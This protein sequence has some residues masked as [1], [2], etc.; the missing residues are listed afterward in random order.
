[1]A[2]LQ[3]TIRVGH[4]A[5]TVDVPRAS[6]V[7]RRYEAAR[8]AVEGVEVPGD[9]MIVADGLQVAASDQVGRE[10]KTIEFVVPVGR[11]G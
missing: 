11:L 9:A 4:G 5:L 7:D 8:R 6:L 10:V 1:M 3:T 2:Q